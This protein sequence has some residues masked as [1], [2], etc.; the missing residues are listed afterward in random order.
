[1]GSALKG[2]QKSDRP[3]FP[4]SF[5]PRSSID[6]LDRQTRIA[7]LFHSYS[8]LLLS[9]S[10]LKRLGDMRGFHEFTRFQVGDGAGHF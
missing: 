5:F 10:Q 3:D 2:T 9:N 6:D 1:M 8:S 7:G 4:I